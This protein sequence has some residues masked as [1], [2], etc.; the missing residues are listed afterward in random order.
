MP[1]F[2]KIDKTDISEIR[3]FFGT[4][5]RIC[6]K[7]IGV[8]Y[9]WSGYLET[10]VAYYDGGVIIKDHLFGEDRFVTP[11]GE[12]ALEGLCLIEAY[13]R[14][15][16][17]DLVFHSVDEEDLALLSSRYPAIEIRSDRDYSDYLY[18]AADLAEYKGKKYHGQKNHRNRFFK[19]YP[20]YEFLPFDRED[21]PAIYAFLE[22]HKA[23]APRSKGELVEY[24]CCYRL[25]EAM[26]EL[27]L[28][29]AMIRVKGEIVAISVG[30]ILNDT[31]IIHIEKALSAYSGSYPTM[32]SLFASRYGE[33]VKYI[34][35]EDDSGDMGL[36]TSKMQYHPVELVEK[37]MAICHFSRRI[38]LPTIF[39][40]RL[41]IDRFSTSDMAEYAALATDEERNRYWGYD[42]K[43]DLGEDIP[44][45]AHFERVLTEDEARGV[46]YS[47]KISDKSGVFLGEAVI[48]NFRADGSAELGLRIAAHQSGKGYGREAYRAVA[49]EMMKILPRLHARCFSV[50]T[51]SK[52]MILAA[53]FRQVREVDGMCYF[54]REE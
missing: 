14:E 51:Q 2:H 42:Y 46:C 31:L 16:G 39:T 54:L 10:E 30:E 48:Y 33:K 22:K 27:D 4:S 19:E 38:D 25:L 47:R 49:D 37:R 6:T 29:T 15:K 40:E 53:G 24:E 13:E 21:L 26:D 7:A 20:N 9:M 5:S 17:G 52:E 28:L 8:M 11:R 1:N 34:N 3:P 32:C 12:R 35:R 43:V 36:R 45:A 18:V 44:D 41:V 50:N 23:L